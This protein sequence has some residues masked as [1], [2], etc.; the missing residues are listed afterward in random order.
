MSLPLR[1][2]T[3]SEGALPAIRRYRTLYERRTPCQHSG[4]GSWYRE[5]LIAAW[6]HGTLAPY[7][8]GKATLGA[9]REPET[10]TGTPQLC[11]AAIT[12]VD[13][14]HRG[15]ERI[16]R[17]ETIRGVLEELR[18][19]RYKLQRPL[20]RYVLCEKMCGRGVWECV[21]CEEQ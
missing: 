8:R 2:E 17:S 3:P 18:E 10:G 21:R 20:E 16:R 12:S 5:R 9:L 7:L 14:Q 4:A 6:E 19:Q 11:G 1:A 15:Q 13:E